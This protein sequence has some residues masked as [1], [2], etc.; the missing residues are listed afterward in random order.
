MKFE[1]SFTFIEHYNIRPLNTLIWG[2]VADSNGSV[3][4]MGTEQQ[5]REYCER[6]E[7]RFMEM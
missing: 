1:S 6:M 3:L 7:L 2:V 4:R 5:C